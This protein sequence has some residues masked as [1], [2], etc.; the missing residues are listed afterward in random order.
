[1]VGRLVSSILF[2]IS[3][4][5]RFLSQHG[6]NLTPNMRPKSLSESIFLRTSCWA[7]FSTDFATI[8][9]LPKFSKIELSPR[10]KH[11]FGLFVDPMLS[12]VLEPMLGPKKPPKSIPRWSKTRPKNR[13]IFDVVFF[14]LFEPTWPQVGLPKV[15]R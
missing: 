15:S 2:L 4:L 8:S 11:H 7:S 3:L 5:H 10:R 13:F 1:M 14:S 6:L 9:D 12:T